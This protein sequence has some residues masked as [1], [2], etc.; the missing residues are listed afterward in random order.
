MLETQKKKI[1]RKKGGG[2]FNYW[3]GSIDGTT[4]KLPGVA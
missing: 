2:R 4:S 3:R 1:K